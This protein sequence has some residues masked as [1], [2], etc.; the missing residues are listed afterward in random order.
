MK[1]KTSI[2]LMALSL[3]L[4]VFALAAAVCL[5]LFVWADRTSH[6]DAQVDAAL[7]QA[8][9][10]AEMTKHCSGNLLR[11]SEGLG[12]VVTDGVWEISFDEAWE[13]S[14]QG[15]YVLTVTPRQTRSPYLGQ[16]QVRVTDAQGNVLAQLTVSWQEDGP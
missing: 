2:M 6:R 12:G 8:Q 7:F 5:R 15:A 3:L 9:N 13:R 16:A 10:A 11:A 4:V 14:S 1:N